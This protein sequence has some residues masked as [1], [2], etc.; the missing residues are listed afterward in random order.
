MS[1]SL[2]HIDRAQRGPLERLVRDTGR[3][4]ESEV[5]TAVELLDESLAG[6]DDY[7]F[8]GAFE[9]DRLVGY[10]CWGPTPGTERT[11]DLYWIVV[12]VAQQGR[13]IG[14]TLLAH[15][16]AVLT[17]DGGRLL[18]AE[19]SGRGD[20]AP[21][22]AFYEKHGFTR[23]ATV[24]GYYAPGD[25]LVLYTKDLTDGDLAGTAS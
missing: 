11:H 14:R 10:A 17:A 22:R 16:E 13:G 9:A 20:Y 24:P 3:F 2:R 12:D 8:V 15:V 19:T 5:R 21:T 4:R 18:V 1:C 6:D 25:D 7:R 23:A